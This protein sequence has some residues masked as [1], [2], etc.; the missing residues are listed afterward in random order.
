[1]NESQNSVALVTGGSRGLGEAVVRELHRAAYCVAFTY[2]SNE[3][4]AR[5]LV[6]DLGDDRVLSVKADSRE[7]GQLCNAVERLIN[8]FGRFD[9]LVNNAGVVRDRSILTMDVSEWRDVLGANLDGAFH[10]CKAAVPTFL[11]QRSGAIVNMSSV[12]GVVGVAGQANYCA[13]KAGLI[14][15]TR[16]VALECAARGVR[17][18]AVAPGFITT[19][20]TQGLSERQQSEALARIPLKRFGRPAEVAQMVSFLLSPAASYVTGQVFIVDGGL[21]T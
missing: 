5:R 7:P 18:N 6:S 21:T 3:D 13:S 9:A 2:L 16:A 20:M 1:M 11:K 15:M 17:V 8:R 12:A 10:A 19:D 14:G 4:C